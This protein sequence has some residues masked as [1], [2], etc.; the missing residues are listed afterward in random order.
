MTSLSH[1]GAAHPAAEGNRA[2]AFCIDAVAFEFQGLQGHSC[3]SQ[4]EFHNAI[5]PL[6]RANEK[7]HAPLPQAASSFT[8]DNTA[9]I[10]SNGIRGVVGAE[11]F[12]RALQ[13]M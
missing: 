6:P 9:A 4:W 13:S 12:H 5:I 2:S 3:K 1:P 10:G 11:M 8:A 7:N